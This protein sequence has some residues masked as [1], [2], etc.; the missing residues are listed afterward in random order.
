M[1][2][3][4]LV[5]PVFSVGPGGSQEY[6]APHQQVGK[7]GERVQHQQRGE[8]ERGIVRETGMEVAWSYL[9]EYIEDRPHDKEGDGSVGCF[10]DIFRIIVSFVVLVGLLYLCQ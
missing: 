7:I 5:K 4:S 1:I 3:A 9:R 2:N 10:E 8:L 6:D